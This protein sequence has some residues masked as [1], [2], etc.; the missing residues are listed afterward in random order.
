MASFDAQKGN[1]L[2]KERRDILAVDAEMTIPK[3]ITSRF[4]SVFS[5]S[6]LHTNFPS[7][8]ELLA[9]KNQLKK[10]MPLNSAYNTIYL[11]TRFELL[12]LNLIHTFKGRLYNEKLE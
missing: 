1:K 4:V 10:L 12:V 7:A 3:I 11:A 2:Q 9:E 8:H 6:H 5:T